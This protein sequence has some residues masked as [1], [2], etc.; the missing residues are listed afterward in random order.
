LVAYSDFCS[1]KITGSGSR[2][3]AASSPITSRGLDGATTL[4]PGTAIAQ[5]STDWECCAPKRTPAPLAQR[6]TRGNDTWP[7]DM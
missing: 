1:K 3:A 4:S 7:S 2:I 5:F 6:M